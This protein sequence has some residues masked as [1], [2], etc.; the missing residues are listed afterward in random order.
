MPGTVQRRESPG[1]QG[2]LV[3]GYA[4]ASRRADHGLGDAWLA[5]RPHQPDDEAVVKFV[6]PVQ[7]DVVPSAFDEAF[8]KVQRATS[9]GLVNVRRW[10]L[11]EGWLYVVT[12][13][14]EARPLEDW[15]AGYRDASARPPPGVA[16]W[17]FDNL[18]SAMQ[19]AHRQSLT[20]GALSP[21]NVLLHP[22]APGTYH[23]W[24][25]DLGLASWITDGAAIAA[26]EA[27]S[28]MYLAPEQLDPRA[29]ATPR[30]DLFTLSLLLVELL[31]LNASPGS[32]S[33]EPLARVVMREHGRLVEHLKRLR[34]DVPESFWVALAETLHPEATR[35]P[36]SAQQLKAKVR[37]AAHQAALWRDVPEPA[38]EPPP[39]KRERSASRE[40]AAFRASATAPEGWQQAERLPSKVDPEA[41]KSM[42]S[43][44]ARKRR[45]TNTGLA[46]QAPP[47]SP[48]APSTSAPKPIPA[49]QPMPAPQVFAPPI[50]APPPSL[51]PRVSVP[52]F[53]F[54][55]DHA[56]GTT[57]TSSEPFMSPT[58]EESDSSFEGTTRRPSIPDVTTPVTHEREGDAPD[59]TLQPRRAWSGS[60][61]DA[62]RPVTPSPTPRRARSQT[63]SVDEEQAS[64]FLANLTASERPAPSAW[65]RDDT[66]TRPAVNPSDFEVDTTIKPPRSSPL[67]TPVTVDIAS[68]MQTFVP[69]PVTMPPPT[70]SSPGPLVPPVRP[71]TVPP[72]SYAPPM[73]TYAHR[74]VPSAPVG[75]AEP[76]VLRP[77]DPPP[78]K[79]SSGSVWVFVVAGM[80]VV[81][82]AVVALL[83][84]TS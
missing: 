82:A 21:R 38:P 49:P 77:L 31:T 79:Q 63:R 57:R 1:R 54:T 73:P 66:S 64:L 51:T 71:M 60:L 43:V 76:F 13:A 61:E 29:T 55:D 22:L 41:L 30:A 2:L 58:F 72:P 46:I 19:S 28:P 53:A 44:A 17:L 20:H 25:L 11:C 14:I 40:A 27:P 42:L 15:I 35:R 12:E 10:G 67:P 50:A 24:I 69:R 23:A 34:D 48:A 68:P 7:G 8:R 83:I 9:P 75:P 47:P 45:A 70:P 81:A 80:I 33:R 78:V 5:Q 62:A 32:T 39:P 74:A 37:A 36:E 16:L 84:V 65:D 3:D 59:A 56:E 6:A 52:S 18:C 4:L 26:V